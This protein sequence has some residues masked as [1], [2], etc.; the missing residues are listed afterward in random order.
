MTRTEIVN[1]LQT[2]R[3]LTGEN[4]N[5]GTVDAWR[6][7]LDGW[8]FRQ[9]IDAVTT[10]ARVHQRVV[11]AHVVAELPPRTMADT[12]DTAHRPTCMCEGHGWVQ[13]EQHDDR[14]TWRAWDRCP[15]GPAT[16]YTEP[17]DDNAVTSLDEYL[18]RLRRRA[19]SGSFDAQ[20][21]L[22][23]WAKQADRTRD[24]KSWTR[25]PANPN[26]EPDVPA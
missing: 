24:L 25:H 8:T 18:R 5:D 9:V 26:N 3:D 20:R 11:V 17:A 7:A 16:G 1:V 6:A 14:H 2:R 15:D 12:A 4:F 22:L 21:E 10:A 13:V 19:A 23:S